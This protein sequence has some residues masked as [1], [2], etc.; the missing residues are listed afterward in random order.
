MF[1]PGDTLSD[2]GLYLLQG[3]S[4]S[5]LYYNIYDFPGVAMNVTW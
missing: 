4:L 5:F 3:Q 1:F 2:M